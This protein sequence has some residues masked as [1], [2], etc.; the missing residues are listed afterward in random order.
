MQVL[1]H[2]VH[3]LCRI[4]T[5]IGTFRVWDH[6]S[7]DQWDEDSG[8]WT[9]LQDEVT[10]DQEKALHAFAREQWSK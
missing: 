6:G 2:R 4:S 8:D 7:I 3:K 9:C 10:A 1:G 5:D